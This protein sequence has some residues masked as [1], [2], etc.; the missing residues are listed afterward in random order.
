MWTGNPGRFAAYRTIAAL[1]TVLSVYALGVAITGD[2]SWDTRA[3]LRLAE[4]APTPNPFRKERLQ[5][6]AEVIGKFNATK[7][8][9]N[10]AAEC[11]VLLETWMRAVEG[12]R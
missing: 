10:E 3:L 4:P 5:H 6:C 7:V 1:V 9:A 8:G 12:F 2:K 11:I